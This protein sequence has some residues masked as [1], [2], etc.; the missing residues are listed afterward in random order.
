MTPSHTNTTTKPKRQLVDLT[1]EE[2]E[3]PI[4]DV[5]YIPPPHKK[6]KQTKGMSKRQP[7][8]HPQKKKSVQWKDGKEIKHFHPNQPAV[9]SGNLQTPHNP[10]TVSNHPTQPPPFQLAPAPSLPQYHYN[11]PLPN[12]FHS[13][14]T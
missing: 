6:T 1:T 14:H 11:Y 12:P 9:T 5:S 4:T 13:Y 8:R 10:F 2:D 3:A 7:H